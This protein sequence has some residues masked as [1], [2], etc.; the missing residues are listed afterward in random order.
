M[1]M[2]MVDGDDSFRL[3]SLMDTSANKNCYNAQGG[4]HKA[5]GWMFIPSEC[6]DQ[7]ISHLSSNLTS[8]VEK[9]TLLHK[10]QHSHI[11]E[12][13]STNQRLNR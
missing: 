9:V 6:V 5:E 8:E 11:S 13:L 1:V 2:V 12:I 10:G 7:A 3:I 4:H